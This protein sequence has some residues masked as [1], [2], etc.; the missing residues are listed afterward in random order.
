MQKRPD[1]GPVADMASRGFYTCSVSVK[2]DSK[3]FY[4]LLSSR[5]IWQ[6]GRSWAT[7]LRVLQVRFDTEINFGKQAMTVHLMSRLPCVARLS[8]ARPGT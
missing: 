3:C 1:E 7:F 2:A 6:S 4:A 5:A 8:L